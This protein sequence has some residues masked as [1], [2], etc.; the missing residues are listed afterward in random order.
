MNQGRSVGA[1]FVVRC[2][3]E[4]EGSWQLS[5][6]VHRQPRATTCS[7][8]MSCGWG[9]KAWQCIRRHVSRVGRERLECMTVR[10]RI[11]SSGAATARDS[12]GAGSSRQLS[13]QLKG[14]WW[15]HCVGACGPP[16]TGQRPAARG[17]RDLHVCR[18]TCT[19]RG[20]IEYDKQVAILALSSPRATHGDTVPARIPP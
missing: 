7:G 11:P 13:L 16:C 20:P 2:P 1:L 12:S 3:T 4:D 18:G 19:A 10:R 14:G 5:Q 6:L 17:E 15:D 8:S 9:L